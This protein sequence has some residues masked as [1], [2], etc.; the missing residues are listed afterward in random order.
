MTVRLPNP[1]IHRKSF[2]IAVVLSLI[3]V[4]ILLVAG[5]ST[6][7]SPGNRTTTIVQIPVSSA[8]EKSVEPFYEVRISQPEGI[9]P[10][11]VKMDSDVYVQGEIIRFSVVNEGTAPLACPWIPPYDLYRQIGTWEYLT[12]RT[13]N[14]DL[15][16]NY[17]VQA[18]N[19]TPVLELSTA[20]LTPGHYKLV[21]CGVSR[22]F[23]IHTAPATT[24]RP[25]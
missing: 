9:H 23:E 1:K 25:Q 8:I 15:P 21:K 13:E 20:D 6:N 3:T 7:P 4:M 10:D 19:S 11:Y 18:G 14:Y 16:G 24:T 5:C 22:E 2:G 17:W 12:K